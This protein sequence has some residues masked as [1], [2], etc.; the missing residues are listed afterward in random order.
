MKYFTL[1]H[2]KPYSVRLLLFIV[3]EILSVMFTMAT[4]LSLADF[5]K[6]LFEPETTAIQPAEA[7]YQLNYILQQFYL[8]LI[9]FG[10]S[11][12]IVIFSTVLFSL[13]ALKNI[14]SYCGEVQIAIVR[15][16]VVR[17]IRNRLFD[18]TMRLSMN[19]FGHT[20]KGD[21]LSRFSNDIIEYE[22]NIIKA[23]RQL[24]IAVINVVLYFSMLMYIST[25]LTLF[26]LCVFPV[27]ALVISRITRHLRRSST[28]LQ[29]KTSFLMSLIE[30]TLSGLRIIKAYTAIEFSNNRFRSYNRSYTR[31]RN[32]VY[33]RIDLA[34][35]V[36]DFMA[37]CIVMGILLFGAYLVFNNDSG[38]SPEL[39]ITYIMMF[40]LLINPAKDI[41]T[42]V[43]SM[44]KGHA[45]AERLNNFIT[46]KESVT[47]INNPKPFNSL[48]ESIVFDHVS[49]SYNG[50]DIVLDDVSLHINK[51]QTVALV[52]HSGSG[53]STMADILSRFYDCTSGNIL[54]DGEPMQN[55]A[56]ADIRKTI[57]IVSQDTI[58]F[59]DT[60][61]N[62]IS[63]G[64][65]NATQQ[66]V[67]E[68][69]KIANAHDFILQMPQCYQTMI[70]DRGSRL[71]GGQRQRISIARAVLRNPD[72]LILDEATSA[73]DTENERLVQN[74]MNNVL[75][76]R[77]AI[78]IAHRLS[79]IVNADMI[80]VLDNGKIVEQG[81]HK[82]LF[83]NEGGLYH[84]LCTMQYLDK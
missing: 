46:E 8:W 80:V 70:G 23:I 9:S 38:L 64:M 59:N 51:G 52:G 15:S 55:F 60:V 30:E 33:R 42:A 78:V 5:L 34:S 12:A 18:K 13:Y 53:K 67:E 2:L 61:F 28:T 79:T 62:N 74:A 81:T 14:F 56:I 72:I 73:L 36:S 47:D 69:A 35:P 63:F 71:S 84:K 43:S 10:K 57:G 45:C 19:Y 1:R 17:D 31:L 39:F 83:A 26:V 27:I 11:K 41:A 3:F 4:V 58:L 16:N 49:F 65:P 6:I 29:Q 20:R 50:K 40:V 21:I 22:E 76:G 75:E 68:A 66:Q 54:F 25:K 44:K 24:V 77:T 48:K 32:K 7:S 37:N 82:E